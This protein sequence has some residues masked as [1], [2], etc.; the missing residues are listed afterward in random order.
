M[1][2]RA[3]NICAF[4]RKIG[5]IRAIVVAPRFFIKLI[6]ENDGLPLGREIWKDTFIAIPFADIGAKYRNV[7]T[8]E[9]VSIERHN[10]AIALFLS[11]IFMNFPVALME[12]I[13]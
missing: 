10:G 13:S 5:N 8:G 1:G 4:V 6:S 12:K 3:N 7:F 9:I 11:D 2:E